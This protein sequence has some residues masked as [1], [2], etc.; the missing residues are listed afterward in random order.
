MQ[1]H[2]ATEVEPWAG[3]PGPDEVVRQ[4]AQ[5]DAE[6]A[7]VAGEP[8]DVAEVVARRIGGVD[9][10]VYLPRRDQSSASS[11]AVV[12][13]HGG[14][15]VFGSLE[16]ADGGCRRL[17]RAS[18]LVVVSVDYR[19]S[20]EHVWPAATD[21]GEAVLEALATGGDD[22]A[23]LAIDPDRIVV[24]G[25]SAGG[26]LAAVL[27]RR[28]RDAGR[29]L[30][31]QALV[32]P[33]VQRAALDDLADEAGDPEGLSVAAMRWYWEAFL[34]AGGPDPAGDPDLDPLAADL[35]GLPPALVL[36][37]EHDI[38]RAEGEQYAQA[39][40]SAG[41]DVVSTCFQGV[42]H[43]F[44]RHLATLSAAAVA[45]DQVAAWCATRAR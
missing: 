21:D 43:G 41:V 7:A 20:P 13:L 42:P 38:L 9:T 5:R 44:F 22:V 39:L 19:L 40:Q 14:G 31:G 8:V 17:A 15:W 12:W 18:G 2:P 32:Y 23:D 27:A 6:A 28:A 25:D 10:R 30:A 37:A 35:V 29:D 26:F 34:G 33:V 1:L 16:T 24:A 11:G 36:T 3:P 45:V 4:R